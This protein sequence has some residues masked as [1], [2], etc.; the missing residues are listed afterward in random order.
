MTGSYQ[1]SAFCTKQDQINLE[2]LKTE[3]HENE[4]NRNEQDYSEQKSG[5]SKHF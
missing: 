5:V 4:H 3:F 2:E 1:F